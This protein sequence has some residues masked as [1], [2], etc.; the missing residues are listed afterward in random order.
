MNVQAT[1]D[2]ILIAKHGFGTNLVAIDKN[3]AAED[4]FIL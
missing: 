4:F 1:L 2:L 3:V